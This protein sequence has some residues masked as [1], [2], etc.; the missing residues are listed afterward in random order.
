[1]KKI[2]LITAL[3][4]SIL[5]FCQKVNFK[6]NKSKTTVDDMGA[7]TLVVKVKNNGKEAVTLLK[8]AELYNRKGRFYFTDIKCREMP[9]WMGSYASKIRYNEGDLIVLKPGEKKRLASAAGI[10]KM[11]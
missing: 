11:N 3:S 5:L 7:I 6:I 2:A 4:F 1:M 9:V 8:P 10:M